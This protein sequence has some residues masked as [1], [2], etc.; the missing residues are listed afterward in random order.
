MHNE[1]I[2]NQKQV[3]NTGC[4][5]QILKNQ[6]QTQGHFLSAHEEQQYQQ[7]INQEIS[8]EDLKLTDEAARLFALFEAGKKL[9]RAEQALIHAQVRELISTTS[10]VAHSSEAAGL[11]EWIKQQQTYTNNIV[12]KLTDAYFHVTF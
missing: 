7:R 9:T 3:K 5:I 1:S 11:S 12:C 6:T 4:A 10:R 8:M 2:A